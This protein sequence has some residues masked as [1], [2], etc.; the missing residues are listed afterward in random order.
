ML[1]SIC[2][3]AKQQK[4]KKFKVGFS[5]FDL[6]LEIVYWNIYDEI[7]GYI[8]Y[9]FVLGDLLFDLLANF[10]LSHFEFSIILSKV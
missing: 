9:K 3:F 8:W 2:S 4:L 5:K 7:L 10:G 6:V 1:S